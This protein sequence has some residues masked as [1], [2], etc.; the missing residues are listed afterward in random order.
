M[1][2]NNMRALTHRY[3]DE[4]MVYNA[5]SDDADELEAARDAE[6]QRIVALYRE[7]EYPLPEIFED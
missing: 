5:F 7:L 1:R 2:E 4:E 6:L 3:L